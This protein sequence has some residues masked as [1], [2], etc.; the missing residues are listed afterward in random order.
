M[1]AGVQYYNMKYLFV[2]V[3]ISL[4]LTSC[5]TNRTYI[6][7]YNE[8]IELVRQSFPELYRLYCNGDIIIYDVYI[9]E[10]DGHERGNVSYKY[11]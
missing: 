7:D 3:T 2:I 11:R 5:Y 9:F 1:A 8:R 4:L 6:K 10:K